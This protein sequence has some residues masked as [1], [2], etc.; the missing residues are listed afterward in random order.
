M[1]NAEQTI[2]VFQEGYNIDMQLLQH[3]QLSISKQMI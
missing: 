2:V 3:F 1:V